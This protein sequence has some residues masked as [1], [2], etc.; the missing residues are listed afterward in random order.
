MSTEKIATPW[1]DF[2]S[3]FT[4]ILDSGE[5]LK[6]HKFML[7]KA[8]PVLKNMLMAN[9][10]ETRTS[11]MNM[12]G[13]D[14]E[15]VSCFLQ[16]VYAEESTE[17]RIETFKMMVGFERKFFIKDLSDK[18]SPQLM[19]LAH[20]YEI[21]RLVDYCEYM[22]KSTKPANKPWNAMD[23]CQLGKDLGNDVLRECSEMWLA[24]DTFQSLT[25]GKCKKKTVKP[26]VSL[27][28]NNDGCNAQTFVSSTQASVDF[29]G[30]RLTSIVGIK[31]PSWHE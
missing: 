13:F 25:C 15:T 8:S 3:D 14:L 23:I 26:R 22:L 11:E 19:R 31:F 24:S 18:L 4:L 6:C 30:S 28:C 5:R 9:M 17:S 21:Q 7:A 29:D 27:H 16:Y 1:D 12:T 20:M 2:L 10:K